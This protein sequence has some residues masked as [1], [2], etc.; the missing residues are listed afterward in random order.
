MSISD[1]IE[2]NID[3]DIGLDAVEVFVLRSRLVLTGDLVICSIP[4][5]GTIGRMV[6]CCKVMLL[7]RHS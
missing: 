6:L 4:L 2:G 7:L 5:R 1:S 3:A